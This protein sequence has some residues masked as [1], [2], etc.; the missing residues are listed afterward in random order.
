MRSLPWFSGSRG[1][2][3][4]FPHWTP[5][6]W[7]RGQLGDVAPFSSPSFHFILTQTQHSGEAEGEEIFCLVCF[8][9][10]YYL[11]YMSHASPRGTGEC[12]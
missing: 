9:A 6:S 8:T 3:A 11:P 5:L 1:P 12:V 7:L 4:Y 10:H 2:W